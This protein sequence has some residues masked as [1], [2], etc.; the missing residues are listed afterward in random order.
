MATHPKPPD[1]EDPHDASVVAALYAAET[2][3]AVIIRYP[4]LMIAG[5][6]V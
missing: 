2:T 6:D 4:S 3:W 5:G 1:V